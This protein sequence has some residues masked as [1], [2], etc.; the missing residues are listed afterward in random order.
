MFAFSDQ[1]RFCWVWTLVRNAIP[2]L[3]DP[4][5][6]G[7]NDYDTDEEANNAGVEMEAEDSLTSRIELDVSA[8]CECGY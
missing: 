8:W 1:N 2:Q 7:Y 3:Q 5:T 6:V 4:S